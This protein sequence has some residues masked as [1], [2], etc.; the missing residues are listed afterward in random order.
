MSH[1]DIRRKHTRSIK[2]ARAAIERVAEHLAEKFDVEYG[3]DGNT[4]E[5]SRGG[6]DGHIALSAK[7]VH[8]TAQLGFLLGAIKGPI[9]REIH[10]YLDREFG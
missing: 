8:V 2:D 10:Q 5:F 7:E 1:I 4:M 6:V 3:W 9:E